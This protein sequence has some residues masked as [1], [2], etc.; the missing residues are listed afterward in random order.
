[1]D[2]IK[3][4]VRVASPSAY[5]VDGRSVFDLGNVAKCYVRLSGQACLYEFTTAQQIERT[6]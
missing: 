4:S 3:S 6:P 1:M 2:P 5:P